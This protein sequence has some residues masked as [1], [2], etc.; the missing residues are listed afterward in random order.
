MPL[1]LIPRSTP[2]SV[3]RELQ[4]T[5]G[6]KSISPEVLLNADEHPARDVAASYFHHLA[7]ELMRPTPGL[8]FMLRWPA[9]L[10]LG[11]RRMLERTALGAG[12]VGLALSQ[13]PSQANPLAGAPVD[14]RWETAGEPGRDFPTH[15]AGTLAEL[16]EGAPLGWTNWGPG[17]G[18]FR[19]GVTLLV[20]E[21]PG[22]AHSGQLKHRLPF[23]SFDGGGCAGWLAEQLEAASVKE[24]DLYWINAYDALDVPTDAMFVRALKPKRI[25]ALGR[26][27]MEWCHHNHREFSAPY[28]HVPHPQY[29]KRFRS[30]TRYPLLDVL[31]AAT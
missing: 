3:V 21:R 17:A 20:G 19:P 11:H 30:R 14:L 4:H 8:T 10:P 7:E 5:P 28:Q 16:L 9:T 2:S 18:A 1:A 31:G 12:G 15:R 25:I 29:W 13:P 22:V 23:V 27:A 26:E 6:I 24:A